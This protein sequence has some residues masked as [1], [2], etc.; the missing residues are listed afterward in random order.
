MSSYKHLSLEERYYIATERRSGRS[1]NSMAAALG[2]SQSTISREIKRNR[3]RGGYKACVAQEKAKRRQR[4]RPRP[5]KLT[6]SVKLKVRARLKRDWSP[7]QVAGR[8][9]LK[10]GISLHH[11]TIYRFVSDDKHV[12]G[13]LFKHLRH[14]K[15]YR[16]RYGRPGSRSGIPG[17][18]DIDKRP[19]SAN[20]RRRVG[21][22]E[23]DLMTGKRH[24]G[25]IVTI[26]DRKSKLRMAALLRNKNAED[27]KDAIVRLLA[28]IPE[29]AK[30]MTFDNGK[31]FTQHSKIVEELDC[32]TYFCKP[33]HAWERGQNENANGLLRQYFPKNTDLTKVTL[34]EIKQAISKLNNR[35]RKCLGYKTP[36]E[37]FEELT[38]IKV[39]KFLGYALKM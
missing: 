17:R 36:G 8:M 12:G 15:T 26:D 39:E 37:Y 34:K 13:E 28:P 7:E 25:Y 32:K 23:A 1:A 16:K 11:E 2:R 6:K 29:L 35:P 3:S 33:Y 5:H 24:K 19:A 14:Q 22:W 31:E 9:N 4:T 18:V 20:N 10:H 27:V 30:T 21:D 38:G